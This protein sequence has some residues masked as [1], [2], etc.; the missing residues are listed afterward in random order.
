MN[1]TLTLP[2][3]MSAQVLIRD[4]NLSDGGQGPK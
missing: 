1:D 3:N 4:K 2:S